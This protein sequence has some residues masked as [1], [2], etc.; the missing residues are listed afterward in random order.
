MSERNGKTLLR[1]H[2]HKQLNTA[3]LELD[4]AKRDVLL[5]QA[6]VDLWAE[7]GE[8]S[9]Q[10]EA[11]RLLAS[12]TEKVAQSAAA[13]ERISRALHHL[14]APPPVAPKKPPKQIEIDDLR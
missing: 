2:L 10:G 1:E 5:W 11:A 13:H 14:D 6:A 7:L 4:A 9:E 3:V 8:V 12:A